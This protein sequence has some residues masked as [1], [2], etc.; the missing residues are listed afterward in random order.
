MKQIAVIATIFMFLWSCKSANTNLAQ[1]RFTEIN[2]NP[3]EAGTLKFSDLYNKI[4]LIQIET[5]TSFLV[6]EVQ[7]LIIEDDKFIMQCNYKVLVFNKKGV[8][9]FK[10]DHVG[11]GPGEYVALGDLSVDN[12]ILLIYDSKQRKVIR[13]DENGAFLDE[14]KCGIDAYSFTK[15]NSDLYAFYVGSGGYYNNSFNKLLFFSKKHCRTTHGFIETH[16]YEMKYMH[17]ADLINFQQYK[18]EIYF[19]YSFNDT[20]YKINENGIFPRYLIDF[21]RYKLPQSY[22][23]GK[24]NDIES[25]FSDCLKSGY[26]FKLMGFF[27]TDKYIISS[28]FYD[29]F[30]YIHLYYSKRDKSVKVVNKYIDDL[31]ITGIDF[32]SSFNNLP[33]TVKDNMTYTIVNAHE[34]IARIDSLKRELTIKEWTAFSEKHSDVLNVYED[35]SID[36]NPLLFIGTLK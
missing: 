20:I 21:G 33:I 2:V 19:L 11:K 1:N 25:F 24:Y 36:S 6:D 17:F 9:V 12:G 16:D 31:L 35:L 27:E 34:F 22:M 10:I 5:D 30:N 13:Y 28:F 15:I 32:K 3:K 23:T 26:A 14:W 18:D 8:P 7:K 4:E 29:G